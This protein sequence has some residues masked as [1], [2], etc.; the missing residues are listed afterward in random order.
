MFSEFDFK[1]T[2]SDNRLIGLWRMM[3]GFRWLYVGA[4]TGVGVAA[5]FRMGSYL[6]LRYFVD[7]VLTQ[8]QFDL[9]PLVGLGFVGLALVQGVFTFL[10]GRWA[11]QTAEGVTLRLR[12]YLYDHIQ[13]LSFTYHDQTK[14]GELIQRATSDVDAIRRF[15]ADQAIGAGRIVLLFAVNF[16]ALLTLNTRL[17]L[18]SVLVAPLIVIIS[19]FFFK[20]ISQA[21]EKFQEQEAKLSTTLQE[22]LTGVRVVKAFARQSYEREKFE[23]DNWEQFQ[24]GRRLLMMHSAF[25]PI[26][27]ILCGGQMLGG[28]F[29]G[30]LMAIDGAISVGDYVAYAGLVIWLIWPM[31]NLGRLIVHMSMGMVS[32]GRVTKLIKQDREP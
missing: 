2:I 6:L 19:L 27:D 32:Y 7:D 22:N 5:L 31:R 21:Y 25:W 29:A 16:V 3:T 20:R 8:K 14:T 28:F 12:N 26:S 11:A 23:Q 9:L 1:N 18:L 24:R 17:A 10:S 15:F 13:R 30:A 4:V